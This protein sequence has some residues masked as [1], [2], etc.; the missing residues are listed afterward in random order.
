MTRL[1]DDPHPVIRYWAATG[2]LVL[3]DEA[4]PARQKLMALLEDSAADVRVVAAEALGNLG[5]ADRALRTLGEVLKTG[6]DYE[7]LAALNVLE[8]FARKKLLPLEQ[9]KELVSGEYPEPLGRVVDWIQ[10]L[11]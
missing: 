4:A 2:C 11:E 1:L 7:V 9:V 5:E 10:S 6:N 3:K 8:L